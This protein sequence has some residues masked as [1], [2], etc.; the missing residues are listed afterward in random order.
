MGVSKVKRQLKF[1]SFVKIM[2]NK[3]T[4]R[5]ACYNSWMANLEKVAFL[6]VLDKAL[7]IAEKELD[8]DYGTLDKTRREITV[9]TS[10]V[11]NTVRI[12]DP[13]VMK[14][15]EVL[16]REDYMKRGFIE[17]LGEFADPFV[18]HKTYLEYHK[19]EMKIRRRKIKVSDNEK[20]EIKDKKNEALKEIFSNIKDCTHL[21]VRNELVSGKREGI[22]DFILKNYGKLNIDNINS[23]LD[24]KF[25]GTYF[26]LTQLGK[27]YKDIF[28]KSKNASYEYQDRYIPSPSG[29]KFPHLYIWY[30]TLG[31]RYSMFKTEKKSN[32][33]S[34]FLYS[35][36]VSEGLN[37]PNFV[38][39][40]NVLSKGLVR[41]YNRSRNIDPKS[42]LALTSL[43]F[44][45]ELKKAGTSLGNI[46]IE[47]FGGSLQNSSENITNY[48]QVVVPV[49]KF[50]LFLTNNDNLLV[51]QLSDDIITGIE[52]VDFIKYYKLFSEVIL[53]YSWDSIYK[54]VRYHRLL[55]EWFIGQY[56]YENSK[57]FISIY[58]AINLRKFKG[59]QTM[60]D[61][62]PEKYAE[63]CGSNALSVII[64]R[65]PGFKKYNLVDN[66][67]YSRDI[68]SFTKAMNRAMRY[69]NYVISYI[70]NMSLEELKSIVDPKDFEQLAQT[71]G[72]DE[73]LRKELIK[74]VKDSIHAGITSCSMLLREETL[75]ELKKD[76]KKFTL[77]KNKIGVFAHS[78]VG[79]KFRMNNKKKGG[80]KNGKE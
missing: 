3:P 56:G 64:G 55:A 15:Y 48:G 38:K 50:E 8:I 45:S 4:L 24:S 54:F 78:T 29:E 57:K 70:D 49:N 27:R 46:Y 60:S 47:Y 14:L 80:V 68:I 53:G 13:K 77:I 16:F 66:I 42:L 52:E 67:V 12:L 34:E 33:S 59:W 44:Y 26:Y 76:Y 1:S 75:Q 36:I 41:Q 2:N 10:G 58:G 30:L 11:L 22:M 23:L 62:T 79:M 71:T 28:S 32:K 72:S 61:K 18:R 43:R 63:I 40:K 39:I 69:I 31:A 6:N 7:K 21:F 19:K 51:H 17:L 65:I 35:I 37:I 25:G 5:F 74:L 9:V 73:K 20:R